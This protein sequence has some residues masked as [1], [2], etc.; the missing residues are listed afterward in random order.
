MAAKRQ[1][2]DLFES[3]LRMR[4]TVHMETAVLAHM[5]TYKAWRQQYDMYS[6][7]LA[8]VADAFFGNSY[9]VQRDKRHKQRTCYLFHVAWVYELQQ[10]KR[11]KIDSHGRQAPTS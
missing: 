11:A 8:F 9:H 5:P 6:I 7:P 4:A 3:L 1:H 10:N 2:R